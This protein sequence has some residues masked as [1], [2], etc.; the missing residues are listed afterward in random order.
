MEAILDSFNKQIVY[1]KL[2]LFEKKED[3][4]KKLL[5]FEKKEDISKKWFLFF[6]VVSAY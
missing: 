2:L 3:I 4:S 5:L 1:P 6:I